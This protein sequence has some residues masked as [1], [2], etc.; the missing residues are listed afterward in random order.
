MEGLFNFIFLSI[1]P[2]KTVK[3]YTG[4]PIITGNFN[5][6]I[7]DLDIS[8]HPIKAVQKFQKIYL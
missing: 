8:G 2:C 5:K 4:T 3:L 7:G 1:P 6:W